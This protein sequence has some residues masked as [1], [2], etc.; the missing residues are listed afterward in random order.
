MRDLR[1]LIEGTSVLAFTGDAD[2]RTW[3][4]VPLKAVEEDVYGKL[5]RRRRKAQ[6]AARRELGVH[7][8]VRRTF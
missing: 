3:K 5:A 6:M 1:L 7:D 2:G 8:D 4:R